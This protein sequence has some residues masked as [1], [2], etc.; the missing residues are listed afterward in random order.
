MPPALPRARIRTCVALPLRFADGYETAARI[1][2]FDGL[3]DGQEHVA[4]GLG[5]HACAPGPH[6]IEPTP[7]L[8]RPHSECLTGDA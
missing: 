4:L 8:V 7:P 1:Y 6:P 3:L 5:A 2:S